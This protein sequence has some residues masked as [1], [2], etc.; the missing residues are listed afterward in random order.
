MRIRPRGGAVAV[1]IM[2]MLV[3][4]TS[5][6]A[7]AQVA[8]PSL[9]VE[10]AS[11]LR[12]RGISWSDG[13]PALVASATFP[14]AGGLTV[15]ALAATLRGSR[16]HGGADALIEPALRYAIDRNG[17]RL[18]GGV[19]GHIFVDGRAGNYVEGEGRLSYLI[20][21][22]EIGID[23]A[24][25]PDQ[26]AIGGDNLY[27]G[28]SAD[29]SLPGTPFGFYADV[30]RSSGRSDDATRSVRLRP[31]GRYW[32]GQ[33][34]ATWTRGPWLLGTALSTTSIDPSA[35]LSPFAEGDA[36]TALR[37]YLRLRL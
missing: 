14:V 17:W 20:G 31:D 5:G 26:R 4:L 37:A 11:D 29:L 9:S 25:A 6:P 13:Q 35:G 23:I 34:G 27:A 30:G 10:A 12:R 19:V 36:G 22:A 1:T 28:I 21:P 8:G 33:V 24:Y 15:G 18:S 32:S 16:R 7:V 3:T 2:G